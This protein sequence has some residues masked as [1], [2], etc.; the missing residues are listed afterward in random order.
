[1]HFRSLIAGYAALSYQLVFYFMASLAGLTEGL[2]VAI[3]LTSSVLIAGIGSLTAPRFFRSPRVPEVLLGA[4]CLALFCALR[5]APDNTLTTL[6]SSVPQPWNS[7]PFLLLTGLPYYLSGSLLPL[8]ARQLG[9]ANKFGDTYFWFHAGAAIALLLVEFI[10]ISK[11]GWLFAGALLAGVSI[12]NGISLGRQVWGRSSQTDTDEKGVAPPRSK[13]FQILIISVMTG[14]AGILFYSTFNTLV[15][16]WIHNYSVATAFIFLG[17]AISGLVAKAK[18]FSTDTATFLAISGVLFMLAS[19]LWLSTYPGAEMFSSVYFYYFLIAAVFTVPTFVLI[20]IYLPVFVHNGYPSGRALFWTSLG[21]FVGYWVFT[22]FAEQNISLILLFVLLLPLS[23]RSDFRVLQPVSKYG[24]LAF[25]IFALF[26]LPNTDVRHA[27]AD[28]RHEANVNVESSA[29]LKSWNT[30]GW[31]N[32]VHQLKLSS[33]GSEHKILSIAGY[34]SLNLELAAHNEALAGFLPAAFS[35][36]RE[37]ALVLGSGTGITAGAIGT[38]FDAIHLIDLSPDL[39]DQLAY[40]SD[41]N[42][43]LLTHPGLTTFSGDAQAYTSSTNNKYDLIFSTVSGAGYAFSAG[44]Y[45]QS[46][47]RSARQRLSDGGLFGTWMDSRFTA[48]GAA[49]IYKAFE[50]SFE[51]TRLFAIHPPFKNGIAYQPSYI[52]M[53]GSD[54]PILYNASSNPLLPERSFLS[55]REAVWCDRASLADLP[56]NTPFNLSASYNYRSG[57]YYQIDSGH[58]VLPVAYLDQCSTRHRQ[59]SN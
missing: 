1:M 29:L 54:Q 25:G 13:T 22:L 56:A 30:Y 23:F 16:A 59:A 43:N 20:G 7:L 39:D 55:V 32:D 35:Q 8:Y 48:K 12:F 34:T 2:A 37:S 19:S 4:Y 40:Y 58:D 46:F 27:L 57:L 41:L 21:N 38:Q 24:V 17:L 14:Y 36:N 49:L 51:H 31:N 33:T 45:T 52:I 11:I 28:F 18:A 42:Y 5:L 26:L 3:T 50:D 47:F 15:G 6:L 44:L 10:L 9:S 53:L